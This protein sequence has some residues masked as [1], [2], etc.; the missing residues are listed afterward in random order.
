MNEGTADLDDELADLAAR[1]AWL[2]NAPTWINRREPLEFDAFVAAR[3]SECEA[4]VA[5]LR[6]RWEHHRAEA[7]QRP[8]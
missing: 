6:A 5:A 7:A 8:P 4:A 3:L 2:A 1:L